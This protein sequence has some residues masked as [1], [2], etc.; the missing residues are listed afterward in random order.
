MP[1]STESALLGP[2]GWGYIVVDDGTAVL[3]AG[4]SVWVLLDE[5]EPIGD[6]LVGEEPAS[7]PAHAVKVEGK[8]IRFSA[9]EVSAGKWM[10]ATN[11]VEIVV[12]P[13]S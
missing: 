9:T 3:L 11:D 13:E 2:S 7:F 6:V 8:T 1:I 5:A 4:V 10:I 12:N